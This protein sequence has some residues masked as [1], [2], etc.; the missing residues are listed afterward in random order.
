MCIL[1]EKKNPKKHVIKK[2][3]LSGK[4]AMKNSKVTTSLP[5]AI[6]HLKSIFNPISGNCYS[7]VETV[8][9]WTKWSS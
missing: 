3:S 2:V 7:T 8:Y 9:K 6:K 5:N 1:T 4:K